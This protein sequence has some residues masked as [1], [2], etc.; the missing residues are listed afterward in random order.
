[1]ETTELE[2]SDIALRERGQVTLPKALREAL[3]LETGD[4]LRAVMIA[5]AIVLTPLRMDL[6]GL[7][8]QI[9][10]VMKQQGVSAE[11]LLRDL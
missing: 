2:A 6:E 7:R 8:K 5:N 11:D 3:H 1:M 9:R 4:S 10:K